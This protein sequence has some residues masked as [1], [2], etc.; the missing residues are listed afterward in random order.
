MPTLLFPNLKVLIGFIGNTLKILVVLRQRK[1]TLTH[2][3]F[4]IFLPNSFLAPL[5]NDD[6]GV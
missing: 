1:R 2:P 5:T 6:G 3:N 4:V